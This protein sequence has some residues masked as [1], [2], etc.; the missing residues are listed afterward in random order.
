[1]IGFKKTP[2]KLV[3]S[4]FLAAVILVLLFYVDSTSNQAVPEEEITISERL[5]VT[6]PAFRNKVSHIVAK[7]ESLSVI[8]E[9]KKVPLNT[10]YKIFNFDKDNV[11]SSIKPDDVMEFNYIGDSLYSIEIIKDD[12]NSILIDVSE[13]VSIRKI[14]KQV[15]KI[16][17]FKQG[18]IKNS[19]YMDALGVGMPDSIIMDFAYIFG[20]D[21]DFIFDVREGDKFSV[22]YETDYI[23]GEKA[24][25]GDIIFA[26]FINKN[27]KYIVQRFY[28]SDQGKQYFNESGM[29]VKKG[30]LRAPLDFTRISDHFNPNRKHPILHTIRAHKGTDYAAARGTPIQ[31]TGDGV[32]IFAGVKNGC[33]N[34]ILIRHANNYQTRYCHM[35]KFNKGIKKGKKVI[36][37]ETI[38]FVGSSGLATGPHLHYEFMIGNKHTD[39]VKVKLPSAEPVNRN[40]IE[41]FRNLINLNLKKL[42]EYNS[43]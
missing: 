12:M 15:Q 4:I 22:I 38:G 23:D 9:E 5:T 8:F 16:T 1:M 32:V 21:I 17:S 7:G 24:S 2:S 41:E 34:E 6:P 20:W 14:K 39:P 29:N 31:A 40:Q 26:Q 36:Q 11:L 33:G 43:N 30:F 18:E 35:Q 13:D 10:A 25:T 19:F 37:G 27:Q 3:I 42:N 28:D